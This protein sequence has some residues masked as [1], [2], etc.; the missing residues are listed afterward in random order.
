MLIT[1]GTERIKVAKIILISIA[2][3]L[4]LLWNR[5]LEQ[6]GNGPYRLIQ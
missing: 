6:V 1:L 2:L 4:A 5:G 3:H